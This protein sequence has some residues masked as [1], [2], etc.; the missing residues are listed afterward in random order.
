MSDRTH[1]VSHAHASA[2]NPDGPKA[3]SGSVLNNTDYKSDESTSKSSE[4]KRKDEIF[5][6]HCLRRIEDNSN[7]LLDSLKASDDMKMSLLI[8]LQQTMTKLAEK[9]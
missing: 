6:E 8:S 2:M 9:L 7:K 1:V 4:P 5:L 3:T